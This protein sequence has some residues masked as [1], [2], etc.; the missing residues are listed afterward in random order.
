MSSCSDSSAEE[1]TGDYFK[2]LY[3]YLHGA[4]G[5]ITR[6]GVRRLIEK[7]GG[8][9]TTLENNKLSHCILGGGIWAKQ[10]TKTPDMTVKNIIA[11][12]E[13]N[14]TAANE[15]HN[16]VWLLPI[17]WL[18]KC[19][20]QKKRL[21]ERKYDFE[22]SDAFEKD[23]RQAARKEE[24]AA[25]RSGKKKGRY[26][27]G[28]RQRVERELQLMRE[29]QEMAKQE[30]EGGVG[31]ADAFMGLPS[32]DGTLALAPS[33]SSGTFARPPAFSNQPALSFQPK[34]ASVGSSSSASRSTGKPTTFIPTRYPPVFS[35]SDG[36]SQPSKGE[37]DA[38]TSA[39]EDVPLAKS[40]AGSKLE[41]KKSTESGSKDKG[42][43][44]A[45]EPKKVELKPFNAFQPSAKNPGPSASSSIKPFPGRG[46][47]LGGGSK[48]KTGGGMFSAST[49]PPP[50]PAGPSLSSSTSSGS[51]G[52]AADKGKGKGKGKEKEVLEAITLGD[53]SDDE[54]LLASLARLGSGG[55]QGKGKKRASET[56]EEDD[57]EELVSP[58]SL[59][60]GGAKK[61]RRVVVSSDEEDE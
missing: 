19:V 1:D 13:E 4:N 26:R 24:L 57:G 43:G 16:R 50:K 2:G 53:S 49:R 38:A 56:D 18:Y 9:I 27:R 17:E 5:G 23:K 3:F 29:V 7:G 45:V 40:T 34:S 28:E 36:Q 33:P 47:S 48:P 21:K 44:K 30:K 41:R 39:S 22:R 42:K 25:E 10:T 14:R 20:E 35:G 51:G 12:N 8:K 31:G 52:S 46:H 15:D 11:T 6:N 55:A 32:S 60:G 54:P 58:A 37:E 61:R 59:G